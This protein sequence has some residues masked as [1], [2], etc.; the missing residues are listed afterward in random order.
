MPVVEDEHVLGTVHDGTVMKK[1]LTKEVSLT[2]PVQE[3]MD[4]ALPAIEAKADISG[5]YKQLTMGH[6]AVV[7]IQDARAIGVLTKMDV[8]AH[9][10]RQG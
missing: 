3:V 10:S 7:V 6:N 8:I 9:L 2:Q 4:V 5:L 1:L